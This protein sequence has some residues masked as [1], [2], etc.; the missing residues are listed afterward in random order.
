MPKHSL[1]VFGDDSGNSTVDRLRGLLNRPEY[2]GPGTL[3]RVSRDG[4][5]F[6]LTVITPGGDEPG[7]LN[8]SHVCPG[9]PG[10]T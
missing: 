3:L 10:C 1:C 2:A 6:F 4:E 5:D 8:D 9:S 7:D